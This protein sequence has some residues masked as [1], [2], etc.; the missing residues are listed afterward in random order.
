MGDALAV[1]LSKKSGFQ[2]EDFARFHPGGN[3]GRRLL[4]R[5]SD[6]MHKDNLPI[7]RQEDSLRDVAHIINS[8][9]LG[10][11]LVMESDVLIGLITD[12]DI[13]RA[14]DSDLD[15]KGIQAKQIMTTNPKSIGPDE[16]FADA[17]ARI[18]AK[19]INALVV[20]STAGKVLGVLQIQ[21]LIADEPTI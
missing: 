6:M 13:R 7:C 20:K 8:G 3:L 4:A 10:L 12:G 9:R 17:E 5:V 11:A 19:R 2:P 16:R 15:C 1:V 14:F 18:R 21:D